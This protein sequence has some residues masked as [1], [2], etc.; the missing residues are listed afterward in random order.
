MSFVENVSKVI[1]IPNCQH[2]NRDDKDITNL[3][4]NETGFAKDLLLNR[5][6]AK[7][8]FAW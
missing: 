5:E 3:D 4:G 8:N 6:I 2:V 1:I 7:C